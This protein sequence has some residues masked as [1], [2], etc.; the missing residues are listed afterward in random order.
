MNDRIIYINTNEYEKEVLKGQSVVLDFYSTECPPCEALADKFESLSEIFGNDIKFVKILRQENRPLAESLGVKSSPT[1]IFFKNGEIV[2]ER[3]TGD[4]RRA[5]IIKNFE[6]LLTEDRYKELLKQVKPV[7][8]SCDVLILGAGPAGLT[9]AIYAA[10]AKMDTI[11]VDIARPGGQVTT[12]HLVS[13]YPGF[14]KPIEGYMLMH[15]M[16]EQAKG[17]GAKTRF[18]VDV[19]KVDLAAHK[20]EI[21]GFETISAKKIIIASG[22]SYKPLNVQ[23][24]KEY[25]GQGISYCATCDAKYYEGK[26]VTVIGGG[27]SAIE[28]SMFISKFANSITIVHQFDHLQ[29]NKTAQEHAFANPKIRFMFEHEP[30]SFEKTAKGML[31]TVED[32]K[33][34]EYKKLDTDGVFIFAGMR[35]NLDLFTN[36]GL[37]LDRWGYVEIDESM[38]TNIH[39]VFAVGDVASKQYRQITVAVSEGTIAAINAVKEIE[40]ID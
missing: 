34:K 36:S 23:G 21:D 30:R 31:V 3:L 2:G 13:N 33:T 28:E 26:D 40:T 39:G 7:Q 20:I 35:A 15:Y 17:A 14:N 1:L 25:K 24:E 29:A 38:H 4:I 11:V 18:S 27:N 22:S 19:T 9:S 5:D 16:E 10:Q 12:T 8:T 6:L 32:L 37:E